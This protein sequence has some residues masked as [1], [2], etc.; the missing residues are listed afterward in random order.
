MAVSHAAAWGPDWERRR[1]CSAC[2]RGGITSRACGMKDERCGLLPAVPKEAGL[3]FVEGRR[4]AGTREKDV[5]GRSRS[6]ALG[7]EM[8]P[9]RGCF[10][11]AR[12][13][14]G[15]SGRKDGGKL[16]CKS[17]HAL[18][19]DWPRQPMRPSRQ[20]VLSVQLHRGLGRPIGLVGKPGSGRKEVRPWRPALE[21]AG[22]A[23]PRRPRRAP[24]QP[25]QTEYGAQYGAD[26]GPGARR[27]M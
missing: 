6:P 15:S 21:A 19:E 7:I 2:A 5:P 25:W 20:R 13:P 1:A 17:R 23:S 10:V 24:P 3:C 4:G 22:P 12:C 16:L 8:C 27:N 26:A 11:E 9:A 14:G 18:S